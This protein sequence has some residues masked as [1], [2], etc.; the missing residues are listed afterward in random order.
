VGK[1]ERVEATRTEEQQNMDQHQV[2]RNERKPKKKLT[3]R[4][5]LV[6]LGPLQKKKG[7]KQ[8]WREEGDKECKSS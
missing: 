8:Q 6:V 2:M 3:L 7:K 5:A 1:S 4:S